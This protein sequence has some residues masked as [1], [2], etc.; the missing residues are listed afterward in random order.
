A[1]LLL[2]FGLLG[3]V[4]AASG[5]A[6]L[7]AGE[8][9]TAAQNR[10]AYLRVGIALILVSG[11]LLG[12]KSWWDHDATVNAAMIYRV[13]HLRAELQAGNLLRLGLAD[14][15]ASRSAQLFQPGWDSSVQTADLVS[16]HGHLLHLFLIRVPD[17]T[18]FW[19]LHPTQLN[20]REFTARLPNL[21]A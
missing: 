13:P 21:P 6:K 7:H 5:E 18:V 16:D 20:T 17:M 4:H 12:G 8:R 14:P 9:L 19:H 3:I 15:N 10:R 2:A 11:L 1:G